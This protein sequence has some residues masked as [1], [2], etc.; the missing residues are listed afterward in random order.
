MATIGENIRI[1]REALGWSQERLADAVGVTRP[2]ISQWESGF[3]APRMGKVEKLAGVF[4]VPVSKLV[5]S[6]EAAIAEKDEQRLLAAFRSMDAEK[7]A[8]ALAAVEAMAGV[9]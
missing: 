9:R 3:S 1:M 2:C 6:S 4:G 5:G 8:M 7:R